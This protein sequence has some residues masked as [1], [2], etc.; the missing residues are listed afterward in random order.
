M[1]AAVILDSDGALH[2]ACPQC[3]QRL[4]SHLAEC[5]R[6]HAHYRVEEGVASLNTSPERASRTIS[7]NHSILA[8][9][10]QWWL[11]QRKL[12]RNIHFCRDLL[13]GYKN[14]VEMSTGQA[15]VLQKALASNAPFAVENL[16][17]LASNSADLRAA[18]K[19]LKPFKPILVEILFDKLPF[20]ERSVEAIS[21]TEGLHRLPALGSTLAEV[22]R[23]LAPT[24]RFRG[25]ILLTPQ[26]QKPSILQRA[27][28]RSGIQ[29]SAVDLKGFKAQIQKAGF[30]VIL[31]EQ[32]GDICLF[33]LAPTCH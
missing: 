20:E 30:T 23:V 6:C 9:L 15:S 7:A 32:H 1:T 31:F 13:C 18:Q 24:G 27:L 21:C 10:A 26:S 12:T 3:H 14:I 16:V 11:W 19:R 2:L 5:S 33:E 8:R 22:A 4:G 17:L 29:K 28:Q 25:S